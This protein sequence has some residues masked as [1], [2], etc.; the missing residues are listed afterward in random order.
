MNKTEHNNGNE[1]P[2][3]FQGIQD[4]FKKQ[5]PFEVPENYFDNLNNA[6]M[7]RINNGKREEYKGSHKLRLKPVMLY[8]SLA[9][10]A[11]AG[12]SLLFIKISQDN[13]RVNPIA[14]SDS[15]VKK[16][17]TS[18]NKR[19]I[20]AVGFEFQN[21]GDDVIENK[22]SVTTDEIISYLENDLEAGTFYDDI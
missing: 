18:E 20:K 9:L 2:E 22:S 6:L 14:L 1:N 4:E 7:D 19:E 3:G 10:F 11:L 5:N 8:T 15:I 21:I 16:Q 12:V 17:K 13:K